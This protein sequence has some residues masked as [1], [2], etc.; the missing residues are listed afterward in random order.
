VRKRLYDIPWLLFAEAEWF[1]RAD[2]I[3]RLLHKGIYKVDHNCLH[4]FTLYAIELAHTGL[5]SSL[6]STPLNE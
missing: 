5:S 4:A 1:D 3:I 6:L 2:G